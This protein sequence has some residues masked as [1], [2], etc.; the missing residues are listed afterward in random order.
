MSRRELRWDI[1]KAK[2]DEAE[3]LVKKMRSAVLNGA[4][5][6][7]RDDG[8]RK[9]RNFYFEIRSLNAAGWE[10]SG[11]SVTEAP[12]WIHVFD[13]GFIALPTWAVRSLVKEDSEKRECKESA[14]PTQGRVIRADKLV[15]RYLDLLDRLERE[16]GEAARDAA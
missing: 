16:A 9:H 4:W 11:L 10:S 2:G 1:T 15:T 12:M 13:Y 7:K 6:V 14:N 5:E 8:V 3:A